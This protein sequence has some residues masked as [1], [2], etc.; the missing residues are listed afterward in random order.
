MADRPCLEALADQELLHE[1]DL[2]LP[3]G[4]DLARLSRGGSGR[5]SD[6]AVAC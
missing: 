3:D 5:R 6:V 4:F 1:H 2:E